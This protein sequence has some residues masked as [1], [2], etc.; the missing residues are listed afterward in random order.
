[1]RRISR[2][3]K[4]ILVVILLTTSLYTKPFP[5]S[6]APSALFDLT[7]ELDGVDDTAVT[8]DN[9]YWLDLGSL[10]T[11]DDDFTIETFF[12]VPNLTDNTRQYLIYK[13]A[14][15]QLYIFYSNT[16]E[17]T[18]VLGLSFLPT[19]FLHASTHLSVGWHHLA[20]TYDQI[21]PGNDAYG[22]Y[23]DGNR[24]AYNDD[25][26]DW[27]QG[28]PDSTY[29]VQI[30]SADGTDF[31]FGWLEEVRF[32]SVVRYSGT[33]YTV[34]T[35]PFVP[36]AGTRALWHFDEVW[37]ATL[38]PDSGDHAHTLTGMGGAKVGNPLGAASDPRQPGPTYTVTTNATTNDGFCS[39]SG[40][41][42]LEA[43]NE[44][45]ANPVANTIELQAGDTYTMTQA[46]YIAPHSE[47]N[48]PD[49]RAFP[50]L[51]GTLT[52]HGNGAT[53]RRD[54]NLAC[55]LTRDSGN[56]GIEPG[57]FGFFVVPSG[58][59]L[60]IDHVTFANAC[61][62]GDDPGNGGAVLNN[63]TL[64][65]DFVSFENNHSSYFG[66]AVH[67]GQGSSFS[68]NHA[69]FT[70]N[71]SYE[72]GAIS[73]WSGSTAQVNDS[74]FSNNHSM[75]GGAIF[76]KGVFTGMNL[77]FT[78]N[79]ADPSRGGDG[80]AIENKGGTFSLD[81][82]TIQGGDAEQGG[83]IYHDPSGTTPGSMTI[84]DCTISGNSA[85]FGGG[86]QSGPGL[87]LTNSILI[88]NDAKYSGGGISQSGSATIDQV[89]ITGN[90]ADKGG[91]VSGYG[92]WMENSTISS[93]TATSDGGGVYVYSGRV[94]LNHVTI[95]NNT[96]DSDN[97]NPLP[98]QETGGGVYSRDYVTEVHLK[99]SIL[100]GNIDLTGG[101]PD[102]DCELFSEDYNLF[103]SLNGITFFPQPGIHDLSEQNPHLGPLQDNG[104]PT[105]SHFPL[106][107]SPVVDI[108]P[109]GV[110]GC[111]NDVTTDQRGF[112]RPA[113]ADG[114]GISAC[115]IGAV[116]AN[117]NSLIPFFFTFLPLLRR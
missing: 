25:S 107:F 85:N 46:A 70:N 40:C 34:P 111:G 58:A 77:I 22:L 117:T 83:G 82:C 69:I 115:D 6:A 105:F 17:D 42:L 52:I 35:E 65:L 78:D 1:M 23:L 93:N 64:N 54:P 80:G 19:I 44:A 5:V 29:P 91:G 56:T 18:I 24:I 100:A 116:E 7:L 48:Y 11:P 30:G 50:P 79:S 97:N 38:F 106:L 86:I 76:N 21:S 41:T 3:T 84:T 2:I 67:N 92:Y 104:G 114:D 62:D 28:L 72:G 94:D 33:T 57:E 8:P 13:K 113:D 109:A 32:S 20:A 39:Q 31:A 90:S 87:D 66:G 55:T 53:I 96:A 43:F 16:V 81:G 73:S 12:Y 110:N 36:D 49:Q 61:L 63:G 103:G 71:E 26:V 95:T 112:V 4:Y 47:Y 102:C 75:G 99:N 89:L 9:G 60:T 10:D 59:N 51:T 98:Y 37:G 27:P 101:G 68:S 108:I 45:N 88:D 15:Y 74:S 14:S